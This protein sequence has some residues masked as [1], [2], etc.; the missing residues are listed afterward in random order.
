M[1]KNGFVILGAC[2][3]FCFSIFSYTFLNE[4]NVT[5]NVTYVKYNGNNL[6]ITVDG[7]QVTAIP[8]KYYYLTSYD[9]NDDKIKIKW[10]YNNGKIF[11][12]NISSRAVYCD[13]E[14]ESNPLLSK[15]KVGSYVEYVGVGGNIG[16]DNVICNN[17]GDLI[18]SDTI[19]EVESHNSCYG[20]NVRED[21]DK[22][23]YTY[24]YCLSSDYK[25]YTTGWRIAYVKDSKVRIVSAGA[26]ECL[27]YAGST[28]K[29][30]VNFMKWLNTLALK[31]CNSNYVDG[32]C[33]CVG[34]DKMCNT[35]SLDAWSI[36]D[37]D[38]YYITK[39]ISG[40][41]KRI[42][43]ETSNLGDS[44]GSLGDSLYCSGNNGYKECGYNNDLLDNGGY[45]WF[46]LN[47]A[48]DLFVWSAYNRNVNDYSRKEI[49][50]GIGFRPVINLSSNVVVIG[51]DGTINNPYK[52]AVS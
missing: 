34:N 1:K 37:T 23:K 4:F 31:Y 26:V 29:D 15:M 38:F 3:L 45:Y 24:G 25:Y 27:N 22:S 8:D 14:F 2:I 6:K 43:E 41:G 18:S 47:S 32:D 10:D 36:N 20:K 16:D 7:R 52:I 28:N 48:E 39:S 21:L 11:I 46:G 44:G 17:S 19:G 40:Y 9:C 51:G 30:K 42:S 5:E 12:N 35:P 49:V 13:L 33:S 50:D